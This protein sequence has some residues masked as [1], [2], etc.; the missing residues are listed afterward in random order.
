ML[1]FATMIEVE[2]SVMLEFTGVPILQIIDWRFFFS[3]VMMF[4]RE[5]V[6]PRVN[7]TVV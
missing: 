6:P 2:R 5:L 1:E 7:N 3:V 4:A